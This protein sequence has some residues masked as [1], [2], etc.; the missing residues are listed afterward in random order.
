MSEAVANLPI[1][2]V[3]DVGE[4]V[5]VRQGHPN[6]KWHTRHDGKP[7]T[8]RVSSWLKSW[9]PPQRDPKLGH[10]RNRLAQIL[11][12]S[13][14]EFEVGGK[15][16]RLVFCT[17]DEAEFVECVGVGGFTFGINEVEVIGVVSWTAETIEQER[18]QALAL[19]GEVVF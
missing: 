5:R 4:I 8:M 1:K 16:T 13:N 3:P 11:D 17:R 19:V 6:E 15:R 12:E 14:R 18:Q 9:T 10:L 2:R 7:E